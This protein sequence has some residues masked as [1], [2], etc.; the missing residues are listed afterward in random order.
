[1]RDIDRPEAEYVQNYIVNR[2]VG[3]VLD[4]GFFIHIFFF[5]V[6]C[7]SEFCVCAMFWGKY[8]GLF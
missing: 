7:M 2:S 3:K 5:S 1:M 8:E 6:A 4:A